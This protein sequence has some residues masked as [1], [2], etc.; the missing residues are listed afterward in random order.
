MLLSAY[1]SRG[2]IGMWKIK[3]TEEFQEW[4]DGCHKKLQ[5]DIV[6]HV[7]ILRQMGPQLGRPHA[8]TIKGSSLTNLKELRLNSREK[9]IRIFLYLIQNEMGSF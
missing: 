4:F 2:I 8:D 6:E 7:E 1:T 3:Q 9:L 5:L